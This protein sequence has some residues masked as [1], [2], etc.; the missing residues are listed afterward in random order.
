MGLK[1]TMLPLSIISKT[2]LVRMQRELTK[3]DDFF[4]ASATRKAGAGVPA[5]R[6]T[7]ALELLA[8]DNKVN[9]LEAK[10]R[11]NFS[12]ELNNL[13][14][15]S[16]LLHLSFAAEPAPK[17]LETLLAWFRTNIHPQALIS[18]G[19]QPSI[20]AGCVLRT[21]N[22]IFDMSIRSSLKGQEQYLAKLIDGAVNAK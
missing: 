18:V 15:D 19:L 4:V 2:D 1:D 11:K 6:I 17:A 22:Q 16:P 3:L 7:H 5:P 14:K 8:R 21:P 9:L 10:Q 13:I 20:A 12:E